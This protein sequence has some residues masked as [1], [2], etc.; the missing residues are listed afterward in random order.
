MKSK[1]MCKMIDKYVPMMIALSEL[2]NDSAEMCAAFIL[3]RIV[4]DTKKTA[5]EKFNKLYI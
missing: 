1:E 3:D 2:D 5:R 4:S